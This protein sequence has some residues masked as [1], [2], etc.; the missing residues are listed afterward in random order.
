ML[1]L[2]PDGVSAL[3]LLALLLC[4]KI[5]GFYLKVFEVIG[6]VPVLC[7]ATHSTQT[8][9]CCCYFEK[10]STF[11]YLILHQTSFTSHALLVVVCF[12]DD[13]CGTCLHGAMGLPKGLAGVG[14]EL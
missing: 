1:L 10:S 13:G 4:N 3:H 14:G 12:T 9:G 6:Q 5:E 11:S 2:W 7:K 8:L